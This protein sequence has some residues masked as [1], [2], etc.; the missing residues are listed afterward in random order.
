MQYGVPLD[1][2]HDYTKTDWEMWVA[3]M[4]T[5]QQFQRIVDHVYKF[6]D[7]APDRVPFTDWYAK[8]L[9]VL[10]WVVLLY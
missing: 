10:Q 2:R 7:E 5:R 6:A 9:S 3:A 1:G 4:G 8:S